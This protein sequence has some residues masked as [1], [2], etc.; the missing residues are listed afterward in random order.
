MKVDDIIPRHFN[1]F[2]KPLVCFS[3]EW[4]VSSSCWVVKLSPSLS[5]LEDSRFPSGMNLIFI[6]FDQFLSPWWWETNPQHCAVATMFNCGDGALRAFY[7]IILNFIFISSDRCASSSVLYG[8]K[9]EQVSAVELFQGYLWPH[10]RH[11]VHDILIVCADLM[12]YF[13]I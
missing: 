13:F 11:F 8:Q 7:F 3:S 6:S 12:W 1:G 10:L 5:P 2:L 4:F 9:Q